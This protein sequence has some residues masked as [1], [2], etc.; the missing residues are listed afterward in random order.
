MYTIKNNVEDKIIFKGDNTD[1]I[2]FMNKIRIENEDYDF[3]ILGIS[4]AEEYLEDFCSNLELIDKSKNLGITH[5][6]YDM[7]GCIGVDGKT[8]HFKGT[9]EECQKYNRGEKVVST[10]NYNIKL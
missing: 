2:D 10:A 9:F 8:I 3:S 5:I 7:Y 1:F 6:T 4:D